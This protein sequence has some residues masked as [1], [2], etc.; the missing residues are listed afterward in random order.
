MECYDR[1]FYHYLSLLVSLK[2]KKSQR[3]A[4]S[5]RIAKGNNLNSKTHSKLF[6][7]YSKKWSVIKDFLDQV[8]QD[9]WHF[10]Y[11]WTTIWN[12]HGQII[13][14]EFRAQA[15]TYEDCIPII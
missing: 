15:Q 13:G 14:C 2:V 8:E 7:L 5:R 3:C 11:E 1:R 6:Y 4:C 9:F 10:E 12:A